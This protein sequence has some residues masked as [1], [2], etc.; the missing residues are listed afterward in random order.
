MAE[1]CIPVDLANPGQVFACLGFMELCNALKL[2]EIRGGFD[3]S[4]PAETV[5]CLKVQ[6]DTNPVEACL[7]FLAEAEVVVLAPESVDGPWPEGAERTH[8]FPCSPE[9]LESSDKKKGYI[10]V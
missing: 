1:A 6:G 9:V 10:N 2:Q 3:W 5:F 4:D 7:H 8:I